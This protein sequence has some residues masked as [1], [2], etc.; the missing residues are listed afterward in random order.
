MKKLISLF[1]VLV[2]AF[3]IAPACS[4]NKTEVSVLWSD[5]SAERALKAECSEIQATF[6]D[7]FDRGAYIEKIDH[8]DYD[9]EG[10]S[11]KQLQ[12]AKDALAKGCSALVVYPTDVITAASIASEAKAKDVPVTF[13]ADSSVTIALIQAATLIVNYDKITFVSVDSISLASVLGN[14]IATDLI[15][16]YTAYDRNGDGKI[17]CASFGANLDVISVINSKLAEEEKAELEVTTL[18]PIGV[19]LSIK[20]VFG[21]WNGEGNEKTATPVELILSDNDDYAEELLLALREYQLNHKKLVTHFIPLYTVGVSANAGELID[22]TK[23]EEKAAYSVMNAID[24]GY[25]SAAA[26]E[27]DDTIALAIA[28]IIRNQL[29]GKDLMKGVNADL[30][31]EDGKTVLVPYTIYG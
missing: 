31:Q 11:T 6:A 25:L 7:A 14:R 12:Q 23:E 22:S 20:T 8:V 28:S 5:Y 10:D 15:D 30:V 13:L 2:L 18:A 17:S 21:E 29:K 1:I 26:L 24:N 19:A 4:I 16:N 3:A 27:D 9:A